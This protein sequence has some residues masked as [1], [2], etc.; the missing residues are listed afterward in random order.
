M[1]VHHWDDLEAVALNP[2]VQGRVLELPQVMV[3]RITA[4]KGKTIN[5][6]RHDFDQITIML[7]G[8]MR[9]QIEGEESTVVGPGH[10]LLMAAGVAHGGEV[11][12]EAEYID[13][14]APPRQDFSWYR[15]KLDQPPGE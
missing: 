9:W 3:A 5:V 13:V 4:P 6:H 8:K 15:Q 12:E 14:F 1:P 7:R 2:L 10:V 11:I